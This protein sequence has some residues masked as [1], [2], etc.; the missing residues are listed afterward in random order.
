MMRV[1]KLIG[2]LAISLLV[3]GCGDPPEVH[4]PT[5]QMQIGS[6]TFTL[7]IAI[8][9]HDQEV[10]LMHR[11]AL[12]ADRGMIFVFP[13]EQVRHFWNHDVHFPLDMVFL[14][15]AGK[16]VSIQHM[17]A[18]NDKTVSSDEPAEYA[19]E[20]ASGTAAHLGLADGQ[21]LTI[22][23]AARNNPTTQK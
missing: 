13:D 2:F 6:Q 11:S 18:F 1:I 22:P 21:S 4:L 17:D 9:P 12:N 15:A 14:D 5:T 19:I 8:S 16:V 10:G 23:P 7:E 20:L 3:S